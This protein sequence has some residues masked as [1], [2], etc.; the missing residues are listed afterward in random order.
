MGERLNEIKQ[1][2]DLK[3]KNKKTEHVEVKENNEDD[4]DFKKLWD[5]QEDLSTWLWPTK[6]PLTPN[7]KDSQPQNWANYFGWGG[8]NPP[9]TFAEKP[10]TTEFGWEGWGIP[11]PTTPRESP[12][13]PTK[14]LSPSTDWGW[15]SPVKKPTK[16]LSPST[17]WG[18]E[19][20]DKKPT[21][22]LSS[23]TGWGGWG[24]PTNWTWESL[25][26]GAPPLPPPPPPPPLQ[27][28]EFIKVIGGDRDECAICL[29]T[30]AM[31]DSIVVLACSHVYH[32]QCLQPIFAK[33]NPECPL[34]RTVIHLPSVKYGQAQSPRIISAR[35]KA[36]KKK[37]KIVKKKKKSKHQ[38]RCYG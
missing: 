18:W 35:R 16:K 24:F 23:S 37:K 25:D 3:S 6:T 30:F 13:K 38:I 14:K 5:E 2:M 32:D 28:R 9:T 36:C 31:N 34:C 33:A 7:S 19:S 21:K 11:N 26:G 27:Q 20:P 17:D 10:K 15:E 8:S 29:E 22:K 1:I 12:Q 4:Y